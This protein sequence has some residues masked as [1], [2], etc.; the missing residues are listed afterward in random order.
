MIHSNEQ[1]SRVQNND[2]ST[3][4]RHTFFDTMKHHASPQVLRIQKMTKGL[5]Y[6]DRGPP[7]KAPYKSIHTVY[8]KH[9]LIRTKVEDK[10]LR[11]LEPI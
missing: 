1:G 2:A 4:S 5:Y 3:I 6:I 10:I 8:Y 9:H 7:I 11:S